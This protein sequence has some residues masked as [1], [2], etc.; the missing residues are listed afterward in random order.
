LELALAPDAEED[1][2]VAHGFSQIAA[3]ACIESGQPAVGCDQ[4]GVHGEGSFEGEDGAVVVA[5]AGQGYAKIKVAERKKML[6]AYSEQCLFG[7]VLV[8][9]GGGGVPAIP[10]QVRRFSLDPVRVSRRKPRFVVVS[11]YRA[12]R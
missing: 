6:Q 9:A 2:A 10:G 12:Y 5:E 7:S 3:G 1:L 11:G 4:A 8:V